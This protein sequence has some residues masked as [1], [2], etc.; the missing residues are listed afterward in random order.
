MIYITGDTHGTNDFAKLLAFPGREKLTKDDYLIVAGDF[1]G[2]WYGGSLDEDTQNLYESMPFTVLFVDG[3]H[4][5]FNL[6]NTYPVE[7]WHG[8]KIHRIKEHVLHLMR[9]QIFEIEGKTFFTFGGGVSIDKI[10]RTPGRSWW[11]EEEP[12]WA[13]C[14]EALSNLEAHGNRV[15][16]IITHACPQKVMR[17]RLCKIQRMMMVDCAAE[18]F[19]D[20]ILETV[21][22]DKWFFGHYHLDAE[23]KENK[24]RALYNDVVKI[25]EM[26]TMKFICYPKCTT[27]QKA[28]KWLDANGV[29]YEI[30]NIKEENPTEEE[31]RSWNKASG[32]PL[33]KFFNTSG[34]LYKELQLKDKLPT[35]TEE[36]Q[37]ALLATDGMLVK[38]P[39]AVT[40]T[41]VLV[42]FKEEEWK[43][44]LI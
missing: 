22:Y 34:L 2:V 27:C 35:M 21:T 28:Q 23:L 12:S 32:L 25:R 4:E 42:G 3:N 17:S 8:G 29:E 36:E 26:N 20:T 16:Y 43:K 40:D 13:E 39:I 38:R 1:G 31:L 19:L 41:C 5:N 11:P 9:G 44:E 7:E 24:M 30:R 18:K 37:L 14:E 10:Y 33:K 15:D 6:L